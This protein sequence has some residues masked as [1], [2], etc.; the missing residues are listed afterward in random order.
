VIDAKPLVG[1]RE[2]AVAP[3]VR[4]RELGESKRDVLHRFDRLTEELALD[5]ERAR[6]WT[7]AQTVAWSNGSWHDSVAEWLL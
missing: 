2:F 7:I 4:S 1:E 6:G 5:R 3:I